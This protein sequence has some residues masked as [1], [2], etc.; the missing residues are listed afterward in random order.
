MTGQKAV[1]GAG[2]CSEFTGLPLTWSKEYL[3][4]LGRSFETQTWVY[5]QAVSAS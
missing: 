1:K 3:E 2:N 4:Y 5:E